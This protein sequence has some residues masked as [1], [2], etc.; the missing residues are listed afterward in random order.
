MKISKRKLNMF[1]AIQSHS[2][3]A[4][5]EK[6]LNKLKNKHTLAASLAQINRLDR[7]EAAAK[8]E[9]EVQKRRQAYEGAI[10]KL[11]SKEG[12]V[13]MITKLEIA[14]ILLV[15][16]RIDVGSL[17]NKNDQK[18][19]LVARLVNAQRTSVQASVLVAGTSVAATIP[20]ANTVITAAV[21]SDSA[22]EAVVHG[23]H[24]HEHHFDDD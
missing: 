2:G 18:P 16:Y 6:Q 20:T 24:V 21:D 22:S 14:S 12:D 1:G 10:A 7:E 13:S 4:N 17:S 3:L 9:D 5:D 19:A 15:D 8:D 11:A 23:G